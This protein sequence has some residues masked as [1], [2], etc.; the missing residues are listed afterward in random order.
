MGTRMA[1]EQDQRSSWLEDFWRDVGHGARALGRT[2]GFTAVALITLALG[3]GANTAIFSIV[4]GVILR[5]LGYPEP[6]QL[7]RLTAE[8]PGIAIASL[9]T[10]EY[11]EFRDLNRSFAH[12]G[13][14]AVGGTVGNG[15]GAWNGAVNLTAGDRPLRVRAALVDEH[16]LNAL[17]VQPAQGRLFGPGETAARPPVGIGGPPIAILSHELWQTALGGQPLVGRT[18][19][20][21]GRPHEVLGIMPPGIDVMD[22]RTEIWLPLGVHPQITR[23]RSLHILSVIGRLKDGVTQQAAQAELD[24]FLENWRARVGGDLGHV[25]MKEPAALGDHTLRLQPVHLAIVGDAGRAIWVLQAAV[26]LV[27]LI[28]CANLANLILARAESRRGEFAVR[29]ALGASRGRLLRQTITE[30]VLLSVAGGILGLWLARAGVQ[31]IIL[32]YPTSLPRTGGVAIDMPVLIF[33]LAVSIATGVLFGLAPVMQR[34]ARDLAAALKEGGSRGT[35][36]AGAHRLRRA[37]VMGEVALAVM[38]VIG[39]GLLVRTVYNLARVDAGFD[40]SRLVTFSITLPAVTRYQGG[41]VQAYQRLLDAL[42][43]APGVQAA[44]AMSDLPLNRVVQGYGTAAENYVNQDGRPIAV[45][46]YYQF[47]MSDYFR[48]MGIPIVAGRGFAAT[49][50]LSEDRVVVINETLANRLWKGQNPIG[51]RL[52]PNLSA[53]IGTIVNPWHTVIGVAK[54]VKEGGVD[55]ETGTELYLFVD[56]PG[57]PVD[58]TERP[59]VTTAPRMLNLAVRTSLAADTLVPA[60]QRIVRGVDPAAPVAQL[61]D[62]NVVFAE[63]IRRPRLLAQL[64]GAFAGLALLLAAVGTYGVLSYMVAERRREIGVRMALGAARASVVALVMR[65]GLLLTFA[66]VAAGLAGALALNRLIASLLF[67][68]QPTDPATVATTVAA[69]TLVAV[70]ACAIPAWRAA[71]LPPMAAVRDQAVPVWRSAR[72]RMRQAIRDLTADDERTAMPSVTLIDEFTGLVQRSDSFPEALRVALPAL[73]DRVGAR[74]LVLL[75]KTSAGDYRGEHISIP[76]RG[77]LINRLMNYRHP[78]PLTASDFEAWLRWAKEVRPE[79]TAEI[80]QLAS[81]GARMAV[82]LRTRSGIVGILLLAPG[83]GRETF[84]GAEKQVLSSA[85][86]VFALMIENARLNDRALE[87][88]KVRRDLA[89]A[90]EVQRR[91][92]PPD[93]PAS[94]AGTIAAFTMPARAIG[95][96]FYDF[97]ELPGNRIGIAVA[98]IAGKGIAAALL[99]SVVQASL[100]VISAEGDIAP[101]QLAGRMNRFLHRST[102]SNGYATFFYARLDPGARRMRYVNAGHNPPYVVRRTEGGVDVT[103]LSVGGTVLGLFPDVEYE[104]AELDIQTGDLFVTFTDG[105][106][107]ARNPAG[108]E[109]GEERL[110]DLLRQC[111]GT[112]AGAVSAMLAERMREW[113]GGAEQHD[114]LTFVVV[115]V[116]VMPAGV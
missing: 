105:V 84:T 111:V 64:L 12:V 34:R 74:F 53:T 67:G 93:P 43:A 8:F 48:T 88:E 81:T 94:T 82:P 28:A 30:G 75:E 71:A 19:E 13:A 99:T 16:L 31:A 115:S 91:L 47:V 45:V 25:P 80:E 86:E 97:V 2:P 70:A 59:W 32:A 9:S 6:Q 44:T 27:L 90:A 55:R 57:P 103:E 5:P 112:P 68:V 73:G 95:G 60:L 26:G 85:A 40:R 42:R 79:H 18:V 46:D 36:S 33:A 107:E 114:D 10:P 109:F 102:A 20:V 37:L 7:M 116:D 100:R 72:T 41:R 108:D 83:A 54:D 62:M 21:D 77:V 78:L 63:S 104:D 96:D 23:Q 22:H 65:Q 4:N 38:L 56:Q 61:R 69:I 101:A 106:T 3:I 87:Q 24:A 29:E 58:G 89:L 39:A 35:S 50:A 51:Q 17:G 52:R 92:L 1:M 11:V 49:D 14:F 76:A 110:K 15:N 66:G 98:D 113:I